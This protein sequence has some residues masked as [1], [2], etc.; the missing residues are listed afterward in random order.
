MTLL[1]TVTQIRGWTTCLLYFPSKILD[2]LAEDEEDHLAVKMCS[3]VCQA[4]L[5]I[6]R[7]H[8]FESI[9]L[10]CDNSPTSATHAFERLLRETPE[11]ADYIRKLDYII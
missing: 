4:F 8:I 6:C 11:I 2:L 10:N 1:V 7:K 3:I 9:V 5:P